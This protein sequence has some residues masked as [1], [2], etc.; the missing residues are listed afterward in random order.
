M[1]NGFGFGASSYNRKPQSAESKAG[2]H[3]EE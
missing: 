1:E 3:F 2:A